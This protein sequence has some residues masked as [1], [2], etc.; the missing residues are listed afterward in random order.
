MSVRCGTIELAIVMLTLSGCSP[1]AFDEHRT[2]TPASSKDTAIFDASTLSVSER[3]LMQSRSLQVTTHVGQ[4]LT[5]GE[6]LDRPTAI[7][8]FYTRCDNP[9]KC[10]CTVGK[11][12]ALQRKLAERKIADKSRLLVFTFEPDFDTPDALRSYAASFDL[13]LDDNALMLR[14]DPRELRAL[15]DELEVPVNFSDKWVTLHG[16]CVYLFD[17]E[18]RM[19][20]AKRDGFW[21]PDRLATLL[22]ELLL[23]PRE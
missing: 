18:G 19:A 5:L 7:T 1:D 13:R 11:F 17:S 12:G 22:G 20:L 8:F 15:L 3:R 4:Q 10:A 6:L 16:M 23:E 14:A 2:V 21:E 9:N